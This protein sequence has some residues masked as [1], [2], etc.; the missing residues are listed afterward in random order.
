VRVLV[1]T[2]TIDERTI[3]IPGIKTATRSEKNAKIGS[4][5]GR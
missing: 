5:L 2:P 4:I 3:P 1:S